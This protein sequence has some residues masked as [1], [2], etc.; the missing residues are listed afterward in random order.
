MRDVRHFSVPIHPFID[1]TRLY[2]AERP[3]MPLHR[4]ACNLAQSKAGNTRGSAGEISVDD[5]VCYANRFKN[6]RS[7]V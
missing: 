1:K 4:L 2:F 3:G 5:V 6:L 7:T